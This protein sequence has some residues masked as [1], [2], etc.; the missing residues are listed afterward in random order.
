MRA[1]EMLWA[2]FWILFLVNA[3]VWAILFVHENFIRLDPITVTVSRHV[4]AH[5]QPV[6]QFVSMRL[7][8]WDENVPAHAYD[9]AEPVRRDTGRNR[10]TST[11]IG[12]MK[13]ESC[14][15]I[16]DWWIDY[17]VNE[18][19]AEETRWERG[20]NVSGDHPYPHVVIRECGANEFEATIT[21][22]TYEDRRLGCQR[23]ERQVSVYSIQY[24]DAEGR[25][26]DCH[27]D[28]KTWTAIAEGSTWGGFWRPAQHKLFCESLTGGEISGY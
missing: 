17:T 12:D 15:D 6:S 2:G 8:D 16:Y 10:C 14:S 27:Y 28:F 4:W 19:V 26:F 3:L 21:F 13:I 24:L 23:L 25:T 22:N 9:R 18:W 11:Q 1:K 7:G 20:G 5:G